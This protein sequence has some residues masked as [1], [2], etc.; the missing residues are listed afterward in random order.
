MN[1]EHYMALQD[2]QTL[3]TNQIKPTLVQ[4]SEISRCAFVG[5]TLVFYRGAA[6][7]GETLVIASGT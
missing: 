3:W 2:F 6:F 1:K 5:E 4:K 7:N